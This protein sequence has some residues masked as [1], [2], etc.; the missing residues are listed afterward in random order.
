[1]VYSNDEVQDKLNKSNNS[2]AD[3]ITVRDFSMSNDKNAKEEINQVKQQVLLEEA[4]ENNEAF[5]RLRQTLVKT[6]NGRIS[7][8]AED[9]AEIYSSM[10]SPS[11]NTVGDK[12]AFFVDDGLITASVGAICYDISIEEN[13]VVLNVDGTLDVEGT[14]E[15]VRMLSGNVPRDEIDKYKAGMMAERQQFWED[16][17][18]EAEILSEFKKQSVSSKYISRTKKMGKSEKEAYY[19]TAEGQRELEE[20]ANDTVIDDAIKF[21]RDTGNLETEKQV[22][23]VTIAQQVTDL[24]ETMRHVQGDDYEGKKQILIGLLGQI[25]HEYIK[26]KE[27]DFRFLIDS[28]TGE[29]DLSVITSY[30][31]EY[32]DIQGIKETM[33]LMQQVSEGSIENIRAKLNSNK[34]LNANEAKVIEEFLE[35]GLTLLKSKHDLANPIV[36]GI[37]QEEFEALSSD[38]MEDGKPNVSAILDLYNKSHKPQVKTLAEIEKNGTKRF[39]QDSRSLTE[40][41]NHQIETGAFRERNSQELQ[42]M[43]DKRIADRNGRKRSREE[44]EKLSG[45]SPL[46]KVNAVLDKLSSKTKLENV[47]DILSERY[48]QAGVEG[49]YKSAIIAGAYLYNKRLLEKAQYRGDTFEESGFRANI[50]MIEEHIMSSFE[51]YREIVNRDGSIKY[52]VMESVYGNAFGGFELQGIAKQFGIT[53]QNIT[54]VFAD[55]MAE[56]TKMS[57]ILQGTFKLMKKFVKSNYDKM[58]PKKLLDKGQ[59]NKE[60]NRVLS[61]SEIDAI[62]LAND[63]GIHALLPEEK[64]DYKIDIKSVDKQLEDILAGVNRKKDYTSVKQ[65]EERVA[66]EESLS[67]EEIDKLFAKE[68]GLDVEMSFEDRLKVDID[69]KTA[70]QK[71]QD[72]GN[73]A[74][75]KVDEKTLRKMAFEVCQKNGLDPMQVNSATVEDLQTLVDYYSDELQNPIQLQDGKPV[76]AQEGMEI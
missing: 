13:G 2:N 27:S 65:L 15:Q 49:Q 63:V 64:S 55:E 18:K 56:Q 12:G 14:K 72:A 44:K 50:Q 69:E 48:E 67:Q 66:G 37:I 9:I 26:D 70:I 47:G 38:L 10:V 42:R 40:E 73:Q 11:A 76:Q 24:I 19:N 16:R 53:P 61:Q 51:Q 22:K 74:V 60:S 59:E 8:S 6:T 31:Q 3:T 20:A 39:M 34:K 46:K 71:T 32:D 7:V 62:L 30:S 52:D 1:M 23:V 35:R 25:K 21:L 36:K 43:E 68:K 57:S 75:L 58:K 41:L 5:K 54:K 28:K 45:M 4:I 29:P 33:K 17:S